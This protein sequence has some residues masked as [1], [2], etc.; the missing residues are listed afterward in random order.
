LDCLEAHMVDDELDAAAPQH[1]RRADPVG[2]AAMDLHETALRLE[3]RKEGLDR[4]AR[5]RFRVEWQVEAH[6]HQA[7]AAQLLELALRGLRIEHA[8]RLEAPRLPGDGVENG[9]EVGAVAARL[10]QERMANAM[11]VEHRSEGLARP[12]LARSR[13]IACLGHEGKA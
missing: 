3:P 11:G 12:F 6:A 13:L 9:A 10:D 2:V 8:D 7:L 4:W 1:R 5:Q